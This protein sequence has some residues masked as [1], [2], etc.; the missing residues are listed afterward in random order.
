MESERNPTEIAARYRVLQVGAAAPELHAG[1]TRIA[2]KRG[3]AF[4]HLHGAPTVVRW[5]AEDGNEP[6]YAV[7]FTLK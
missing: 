3:G 6:S 4:L 7:H 5:H 1:S 2:L